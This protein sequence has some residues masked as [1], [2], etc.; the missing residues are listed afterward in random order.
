MRN[1]SVLLLLAGLLVGCSDEA[2]VAAPGTLNVTVVG[3]NGAEG[4]AI[5]L[6]LGDGIQSVSAVAPTELHAGGG[7][8]QTRLVLIHPSGG[9]LMFEVAMADTTELPA[10]VVEEVAGPDDELRSD[11]AAYSLEFGR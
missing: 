8:S 11:V 1:R 10:W 9:D 3:P 7:N 5:V 4:A 6:L 2:P